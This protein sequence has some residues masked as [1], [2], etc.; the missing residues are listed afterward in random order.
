M[1]GG[2]GVECVGIDVADVHASARIT[3]G[4]GYRRADPGCSACH[5]RALAFERELFHRWSRSAFGPGAASRSLRAK[6]LDFG[7]AQLRRHYVEDTVHILVAV[8]PA[9]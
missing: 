5:Q 1:P 4:C 7:A 8:D 9:E 2:K 3:I 6:M